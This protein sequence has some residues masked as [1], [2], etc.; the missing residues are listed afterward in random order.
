AY[1]GPHAI[2]RIR[3]DVSNA[4]QGIAAADLAYKPFQQARTLG[5]MSNLGVK[6]HA[7][8][9]APLIAHRSV[10]DGFGRRIDA[11]PLRQPRNPIAMAHPAI[12]NRAAGGIAAILDVIQQP[13][14]RSDGNRGVAEFPFGGGCD[15]ATELLGHG[16]HAVADT[17]YR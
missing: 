17:Q 13:R 4:P 2:D 5:C 9:A 14:G 6:L 3:D 1:L 11:E 10:W 7:V 12:E 8:K 15:P 16:L